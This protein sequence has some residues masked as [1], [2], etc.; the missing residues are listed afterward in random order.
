[1]I[2]ATR[3][4]LLSISKQRINRVIQLPIERNYNK[5]ALTA[6]FVVFLL[7]ILLS[8]VKNMLIGSVLA[9]LVSCSLYAWLVVKIFHIRK[10][11]PASRRRLQTSVLLYVSTIFGL[12]LLTCVSRIILAYGVG[13]RVE[14]S[15]TVGKSWWVWFLLFFNVLHLWSDPIAYFLC[16]AKLKDMYVDLVY[17]L[18]YYI[19]KCLQPSFDERSRS[20]V[21][22]QPFHMHGN[23]VIVLNKLPTV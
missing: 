7:S 14:N 21:A 8:L 6:S 17:K 5:Y 10:I 13:E 9:T 23:T 20:S 19:Q 16:H 1:M 18:V 12:Y 11:S 3:I 15:C 4:R 22:P 2:T